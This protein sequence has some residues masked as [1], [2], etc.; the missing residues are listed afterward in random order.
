V[1]PTDP[2]RSADPSRAQTYEERL[3]HYNLEELEQVLAGIEER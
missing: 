3:V 2:A 1:R